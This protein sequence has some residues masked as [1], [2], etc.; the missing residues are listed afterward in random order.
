[1]PK[2]GTTINADNLKPLIQQLIEDLKKEGK[3]EGITPDQEL[4]LVK[5]VTEN[6]MGNVNLSKGDFDLRDN[7]EGLAKL[8]VLLTETIKF[9]FKHNKN[10]N[11]QAELRPQLTP[12]QL[13]DKEALKEKLLPLFAALNELTPP[14]PGQAHK[15]TDEEIKKLAEQA[16]SKIA[17]EMKQ[18]DIKGNEKEAAMAATMYLASLF[19]I[20]P[21]GQDKV[22]QLTTVVLGD[23]I[24]L[25]N[26]NEGGGDNFMSKENT[27]EP[28]K[29]DPT[30]AELT[31]LL[32]AVAAASPLMDESPLEKPVENALAH[33]VN[34][35]QTFTPGQ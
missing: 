31:T 34:P 12:E 26:V 19:G 29:E 24:G 13:Q 33:I 35:S 7:R 21:S 27:A 4:A 6:V 10:V 3:L 11:P 23:L 20:D 25:P 28:G 32:S 16:A 22:G 14:K 5:A 8:V 2:S 30:G 18:Q 1:M 15:F 17:N 9:E